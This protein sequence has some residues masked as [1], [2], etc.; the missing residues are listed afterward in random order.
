VIATRS[1][2][3]I[4][5]DQPDLVVSATRAVLG[6]ARHHTSLPACKVVFAPLG[7]ACLAVRTQR[8]G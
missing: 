5:L 3:F 4:Q 2:H 7:G 6:A 1:G 8:V